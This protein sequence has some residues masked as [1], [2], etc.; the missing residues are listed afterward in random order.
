MKGDARLSMMKKTRKAD[1][2]IYA[3][4][5]IMA[6]QLLAVYRIHPARVQHQQRSYEEV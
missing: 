4:A 3:L 1:S 6:M 5:Y 2:L